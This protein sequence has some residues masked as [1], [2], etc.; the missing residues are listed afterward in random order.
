M[1]KSNSA[2]REFAVS[3]MSCAACSAR[4][5]KA[6]KALAAV[7]DCA[8]SLL[9]GSMRVTGEASD[10]AI[11]SAVLAAGYGCTPKTGEK[12]REPPDGKDAQK[13][14]IQSLR[15]RFLSSLVLLLPLMYVSMGHMAGLPLPPPLAEHLALRGLTELLLA[16]VILMINRKF[17][18][19][20]ARGVWHRAPNMDT[21]VGLGSGISYLWSVYVL[22]EVIL[23]TAEGG[24]AALDALSHSFYFESASMI[25][26]L[27][28]LG[29]LLEAGAKGKTTDAIRALLALHPEQAT[30]LRE[31]KEVRIPSEEIVTGDTVILHAGDRVPA[32]GRVTDGEGAF[33]ESAL[34]GESI[35]ADK[36]IG[37]RVYTGT[38]VLSGYLT[39]TATEVGEETTLSRIVQTVKEAS[40][41]KAPIASLAD[42]VAGVFVPTVLGLS[43]IT[44]VAWLIAGEAVATALEHA[45][46][47]LV[48]SCPCALGLA[49]PVA[50]MVGSGRAASSGVLFKTAT[51]LEQTGRAR[52][53]VF[54]KT[55]TLTH[56]K[57]RVCEVIPAPDVTVERLLTVA[58]SVEQGSEHPLGRAV[59]AYAA[60]QGVSPLSVVGFETHAGSGVTARFADRELRGGK[61]DFMKTSLPEALRAQAETLA[62][63]G[64]TPLFFSEGDELLGVIA[65]ADTV[66]ED[67]V[68]AL[69]L[70]KKRGI[71]TVMLT[72][73]HPKTAAAVAAGLP[74]DEVHAGVLP[75]GK[76]E[77]VQALMKEGRVLMIGDGINDAPA[78]T[79]ADV[80]MAVGAG[81]DI[82]M[83]SAD[84]VLTGSGLSD[85]LLA[86]DIAKSTLRCI[87]QN[88][89]WAFF[90][91]L[92]GIP[93]AAGLFIP[94]LGWSLPPMF[95][96]AAMSL[97]SLTVVSNALRLRLFKPKMQSKNVENANKNLQ[98]KGENKMKITMKITGMM[99]PHCS[100]RVK[101]LLEA[102]PFVEAAEVSHERGEAILSVTEACDKAQLRKTVEDAGYTV[103]E[104]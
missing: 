80:G 84:V 70:L 41:T 9:T 69:A 89:F 8:V 49:T 13:K 93:L 101:G 99:C 78:L 90:Y 75:A 37:A 43:L 34:T 16:T 20:G 66:K 83:D 79:V 74:I 47:V 85:V 92:I 77:V 27:I 46:C 35:P 81:T 10:E 62:G 98:N 59:T 61:A 95:G 50:I 103:T 33:D 57:P 5:E 97:S 91:N 21:L 23:A 22:Y 38:V 1:K 104:V 54:D 42:R 4:V 82:A 14:E 64:K 100:G 15:V 102:L 24:G 30:V 87:K 6:V 86:V 58:R 19:N 18:V 67:A 65:V 94:L 45:V 2:T 71:R 55:G 63:Q 3:G 51:A 12:R 31:G 32:D 40:S 52:I 48:I 28:T 76:A 7:E 39:F 96:A 53:A 88:L 17:F 26:V 73:D 25:L 44:L 29:K 68:T 60:E 72:G 36:G 56:G 11:V